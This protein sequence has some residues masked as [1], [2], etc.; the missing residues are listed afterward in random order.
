[1]ETKMKVP[2]EEKESLVKK[3]GSVIEKTKEKWGEKEEELISEAKKSEVVEKAK[4]KLG[5]LKEEAKS[6]V[7][8]LTEK[9]PGKSKE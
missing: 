7:S 6:L 4:E 9:V 1:M 2:E 8:N 3:A 5:G